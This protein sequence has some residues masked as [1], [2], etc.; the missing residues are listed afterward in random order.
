MLQYSINA[1]SK[2]EYS[3]QFICLGIDLRTDLA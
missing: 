3:L 2:L 1:T